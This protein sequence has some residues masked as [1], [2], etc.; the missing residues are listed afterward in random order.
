MILLTNN[1]ETELTFGK[2]SVVR[3]APPCDHI[4]HIWSGYCLPVVAET[5]RLLVSWFCT[6]LL[7]LLELGL[8]SIIVSIFVVILVEFDNYKI[9]SKSKINLMMRQAGFS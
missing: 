2:R 9:R 1:A 8:D 7:L 6:I 3:L 5:L 4:D